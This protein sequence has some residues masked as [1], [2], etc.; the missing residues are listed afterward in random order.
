M[1]TPEIENEELVRCEALTRKL[2]SSAKGKSVNTR[3]GIVAA[4][5]R[6]EASVLPGRVPMFGGGFVTCHHFQKA[7]LKLAASRSLI[8]LQVLQDCHFEGP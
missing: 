6:T 7:A 1:N 4:A 3:R 8:F 5:C 2:I